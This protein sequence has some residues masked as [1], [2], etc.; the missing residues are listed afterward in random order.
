MNK[1]LI[2]NVNGHSKGTHI[3]CLSCL[4]CYA[5]VSN[6]VTLVTS[7]CIDKVARH[8]YD[9]QSLPRIVFSISKHAN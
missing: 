1:N 7:I 8:D 3:L 9:V 5:L 6:R 4:V 2:C